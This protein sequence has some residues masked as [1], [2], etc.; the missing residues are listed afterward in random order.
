[1]ARSSVWNGGPYTELRPTLPKVYAALFIEVELPLELFFA[2]TL[3]PLVIR[4]GYDV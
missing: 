1:M 2:Q 3:G 4:I